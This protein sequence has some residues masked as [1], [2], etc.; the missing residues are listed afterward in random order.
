VFDGSKP[1][2]ILPSGTIY[3]NAEDRMALALVLTLKTTIRERWKQVVSESTGCPIFLATLDE[4][5]PGKTLDKLENKGI[6]LVVPEQ[7]K[8]S[9][10]AEYASRPSVITYRSFFE[11]LLSERCDPWLAKGIPCFGIGP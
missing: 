7:F 1:D 5:V 2:F 11:T 8:K 6:T 10:F 4:S 3:A 9:E